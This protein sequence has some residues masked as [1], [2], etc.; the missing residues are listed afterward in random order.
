MKK[1]NKLQ[2][3]FNLI[4]QWHLQAEEETTSDSPLQIQAVIFGQEISSH[5][6]YTVT[7]CN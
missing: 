5:F 2:F 4:Q 7:Y 6:L 1:S 3:R